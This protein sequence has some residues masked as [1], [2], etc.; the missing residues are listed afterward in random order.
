MAQRTLGAIALIFSLAACTPNPDRLPTPARNF[1]YVIDDD[2][3]QLEYVKLK[4][5][6][7]Q[8][9]LEGAGLW[10]KWLELSSEERNA[11]ETSEIKVGFKEFAAH[12][13]WGLPASTRDIEARGRVVQYQTFIRCTS[14]PKIGDYV[15]INTDCD[16]TSS[17]VELAVENATVTE[18]KY[19]D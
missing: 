7:R 17:E 14:G 12:M 10:Q 9:F 16:G 15:R 4:E 8:G 1:Y 3:Q 11:V 13:A 18:I 5:S 19:L 6:E 2:A